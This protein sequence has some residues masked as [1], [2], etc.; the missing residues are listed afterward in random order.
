MEHVHS[1]RKDLKKCR[2]A[3]FHDGVHLVQTH[4][5]TRLLLQE[6]SFD[7]PD[8]QRKLRNVSGLIGEVFLEA[9][10]QLTAPLSGKKIELISQQMKKLVDHLSTTPLDELLNDGLD[11]HVYYITGFLCRAGEKKEAAR[12]SSDPNSSSYSI[13]Q[14]IKEV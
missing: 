1:Y 9:Y 11:K 8:Q 4:F 14:C 13:G 5:R 2:H 10:E 3:C 12:R 7:P 6:Y